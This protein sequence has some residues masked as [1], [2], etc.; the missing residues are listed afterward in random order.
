MPNTCLARGCNVELPKWTTLCE[1][2]MW[3]GAVETALDEAMIDVFNG[4]SSHAL[5]H[6]RYAADKLREARDG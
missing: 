2:H 6:L 1:D 5:E 4:N 3:M